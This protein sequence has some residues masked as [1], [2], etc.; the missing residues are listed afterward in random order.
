[1]NKR[2]KTNFILAMIPTAVLG[3]VVLLALLAV[4][5]VLIFDEQILGYLHFL[6]GLL[7]IL[8]FFAGGLAVLIIILLGGYVAALFAFALIPKLLIEKNKGRLVAYRVL[9]T[10]EYLLQAQIVLFC[11]GMMREEISVFWI[12]V[13]VV[14]T[15]LNVISAINTYTK[16]ILV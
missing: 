4:V 8:E 10:I 14:V 6:G 16:R 9:M 5:A 7:L 2:V 12:A 11:V 15:V 13:A 1:M 3:L